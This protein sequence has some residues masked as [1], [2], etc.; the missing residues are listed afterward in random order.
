MER[1][2]KKS[3]VYPVTRR[4]VGSSLASTAPGFGEYPP[5]RRR[6]HSGT[7]CPVFFPGVPIDVAAQ[8]GDRN[9]PP[10][11]GTSSW[12]AALE[13]RTLRCRR[14][15]L[16]W[17]ARAPED[18][19]LRRGSRI[20]ETRIWLM[21]SARRLREA[22]LSEEIQENRGEK[23]PPRQMID[24][25]FSFREPSPFGINNEMMGTRMPRSKDCR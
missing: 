15:G 22:G 10:E 7:C 14:G 4:P 8:K 16:H 13:M 21:W 6:G 5:P 24:S 17:K 20:A 19:D 25:I 23:K 11:R 3:P 18:W 1:G 9:P 2:C 12:L